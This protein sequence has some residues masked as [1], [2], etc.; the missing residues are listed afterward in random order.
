M[1][2]MT[3]LPEVFPIFALGHEGMCATDALAPMVCSLVGEDLI[4]K[5]PHFGG[6]NS[7]QS[8]YPSMGPPQDDAIS[9]ARHES[10]FGSCTDRVR[11]GETINILCRK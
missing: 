7:V 2:E 11:V 8:F 4:K 3:R 1:T 9:R 10:Y 6:E 5:I